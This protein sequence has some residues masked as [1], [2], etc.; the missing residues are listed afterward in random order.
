RR[1]ACEYAEVHAYLDRGSIV[2]MHRECE[3]WVDHGATT[4]DGGDRLRSALAWLPAEAANRSGEADCAPEEHDGDRTAVRPQMVVAHHHVAR[5][6]REV[7]E[8][9]D[10]GDRAQERRILLRREERSR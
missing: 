1:P 2:V 10:V 9:Q 5:E 8:R 6:L 4:A 3:L 7:R